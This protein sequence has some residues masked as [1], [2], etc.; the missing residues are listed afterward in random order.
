LVRR[1]G[2]GHTGYNAGNEC[3]DNTV[4][5]YLVSGKI[6]KSTVDC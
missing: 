6:P 2:D 5:S 3:V 4:E 1:D